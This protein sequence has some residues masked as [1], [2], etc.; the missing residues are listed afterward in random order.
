MSFDFLVLRQGLSVEPRLISD[1]RS[2]IL[3]PE[4]PKC[5]DYRCVPVYLPLE[6]CVHVCVC[7]L[8]CACIC[9]FCVSHCVVLEARLNSPSSAQHRDSL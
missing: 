7:I 3:A 6:D 8:F 9:I 4:A 1:S 5:W 2:P